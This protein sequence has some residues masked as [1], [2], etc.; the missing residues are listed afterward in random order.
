MGRTWDRAA[1][2]TRAYNNNLQPMCGRYYRRSDKQK[3]AEAF[4]VAQVEDFPLPSWD[5]NVAPTTQQPI[6]R[7][8]GDTSERSLDVEGTS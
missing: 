8:N 6:I 2:G 3:I 7:N 5:Y 1:S 4:H